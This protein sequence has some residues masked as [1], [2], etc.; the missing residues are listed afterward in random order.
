VTWA[1][2][3]TGQ[4][5]AP[6]YS[7]SALER[8]QGAFPYRYIKW[9]KR[10]GMWQIRQRNPDSGQ[11]ERV[12]LV[13]EY[14]VPEE[15]VEGYSGEAKARRITEMVMQSHPAVRKAYVPFDERFVARRLKEK[16]LF[17]KYGAKH[18]TRH[19]AAGRNEE[20]VLRRISFVADEWATFVR[21]DQHWLTHLAELT[22]GQTTTQPRKY[23]RG[24]TLTR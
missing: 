19:T 18:Y 13:F 7:E 8:Y 5:D 22:D 10:R 17:E 1:E 24:A 21:Q 3:R 14:T 23:V 15:L 11:D 9:D 16:R 12:E 6:E 4:G 20:N 2:T